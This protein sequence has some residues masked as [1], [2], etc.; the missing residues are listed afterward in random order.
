M[1][2]FLWIYDRNYTIQWWISTFSKWTENR[3]IEHLCRSR[4]LVIAGYT[5]TRNFII[6]NYRYT[7]IHIDILGKFVKKVYFRSLCGVLRSV[8]SLQINWLTK[9]QFKNHVLMF[10][11]SFGGHWSGTNEKWNMIIAKLRCTAR[12]LCFH[13]IKLISRS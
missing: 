12:Q 2:S 9:I 8:F 5:V 13:L 4:I 11:V 6:Y 3:K 7:A 10:N 1:N